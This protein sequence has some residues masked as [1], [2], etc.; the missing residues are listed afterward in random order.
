MIDEIT[1]LI[2]TYNEAPNIA[3]TLDRLVWARRIVVVDSG[4]TDETVEIVRS[5]PQAEVLQRPFDDCASQWNFGNSQVAGGWIL[6][7]DADYELSEALVAEI[8]TLRPAPTTSGYRA[9]FVYRMFGRALRGSLYPPRIVLYRKDKSHYRNEGHTQQLVVSGEVLPL[10][11]TIFHDDRKPIARWFSSQR[12]YARREADYL[13]ASD[14]RSLTRTDRIRLAAWPAPLAVLVYTL[15]VKR[16]LLDGWP[17]WYYALQRV[18]A[19][20]MIAL[21]L[22]DRRIRRESRN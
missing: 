3:R 21:E 5:Y 19:E 16:C 1:P 6:S 11:G 15:V 14:R 2:I 18:C 9:Q 22:I 12:Q 17:G 7:L 13:L 4:S 20:T 10:A 8:G